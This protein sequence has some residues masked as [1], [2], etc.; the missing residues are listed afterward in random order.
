M[1]A[2][3]LFA[4]T[5]A[6]VEFSLFKKITKGLVGFGYLGFW[7]SPGLVDISD[8]WVKGG[9]YHAEVPCPIPA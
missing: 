9:C 2:A 1:I 6:P 5:I 8:L 3:G 4:A 7:S